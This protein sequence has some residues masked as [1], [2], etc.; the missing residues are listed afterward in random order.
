MP[1]QCLLMR[2]VWKMAFTFL[3]WP[4]AV[5]AQ[6]PRPPDQT[7]PS[8][9]SPP[10]ED[11]STSSSD[12]T[13]TP[14]PPPTT[15]VTSPLPP[16]T[17]PNSLPAPTPIL[18]GQTAAPLAFRPMKQPPIAP[19][20]FTVL[21][22]G[23][24]YSVT[25]ISL[26]STGRVALSGVDVNVAADGGRRIGAE[27]DLSYTL[28]A[29]VSNTGHRA[30]VF[31]YLVGPMFSL[32]RG[33]SLSTS[34]HVLVGG[35]RVAGPFQTSSGGLV[36]GHVHYPA[37]GFGG[38]AEYAVSPALGFRVTIDCLHT[39]FFDSSGA[40]RGQ[41]DIRVVNSLVYYLGEPVIRSRHRR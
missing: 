19:G 34:A 14:S 22:L 27:L 25:N 10:S 15:T 6:D 1:T 28:S 32:W 2:T 33:D 16:P 7:N 13:T 39:N 9:Q 3:I 40:V 12:T 36:T 23:A 29:N 26:P 31:S 8:V 35:A 4:I 5:M 18:P 24:G 38:S 41:F 30:D 21:N 37:W 11:N 20:H 17:T